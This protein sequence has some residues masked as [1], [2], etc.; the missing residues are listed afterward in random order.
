MLNIVAFK[1]QKEDMWKHEKW[2]V[3]SSKEEMAQD[4]EGWDGKVQKLLEVYHYVSMG[5]PD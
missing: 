3:E 1:K 2:V 4:F 5:K